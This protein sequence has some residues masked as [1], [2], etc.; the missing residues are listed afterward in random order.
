MITARTRLTS[1][2]KEAF[3]II[4]LRCIMN[5]IKNLTDAEYKSLINSVGFTDSE[6]FI[7]KHYRIGDMTL[8]G[9]AMDLGISEYEARKS[10]DHAETKVY[11]RASRGA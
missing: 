11:Q 10:K 4:L 7:I 2:N 5:A 9:M 1:N 8:Q 3:I 6:M